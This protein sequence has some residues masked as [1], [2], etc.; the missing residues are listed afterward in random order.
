MKKAKKTAKKAVKKTKAKG[1]KIELTKE[2]LHELTSGDGFVGKVHQYFDELEKK[3]MSDKDVASQMPN[4]LS[5]LMNI[6]LECRSL[7]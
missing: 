6:R 5:D 7:P 2:Q 4:I 1:V 3:G